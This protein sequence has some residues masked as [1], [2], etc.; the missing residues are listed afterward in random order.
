M[1]AAIPQDPS[2]FLAVIRDQVGAPKQ[3]QKHLELVRGVCDWKAFFEPL[4]LSVHGHART[5]AM[6]EKGVD[7]V[8]CF[9]FQRSDDCGRPG[10]WVWPQVDCLGGPRDVVLTA[11]MHMSSVEVCEHMVF[12]HDE[13]FQR[14][15]PT[16][17]APVPLRHADAQQ[18]KEYEKTAVAVHRA[19]WHMARAAQYLRSLVAEPPP[20]EPPSAGWF[21]E[22]ATPGPQWPN[23]L[24]LSDVR[25]LGEDKEPGALMVEDRVFKVRRTTDRP[26]PDVAAL[27]ASSSSAVPTAAKA[28]P[29]AAPAPP[30]APPAVPKAK[31]KAKGKAQA[32]PLCPG[33]GCGKCRWSPNGC[34]QCK[35]RKGW[36]EVDPGKWER[37]E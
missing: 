27:A 30:A 31:A 3:H 15:P 6:R 11:K 32:L 19:P 22:P 34:R 36:V 23:A 9:K 35:W 18:V 16:Q 21:W 7:A 37:F 10:G 2:D 29:A 8:H 5:H 25:G 20:P 4:G 13:A 26:P 33:L 1:S 17:P 28:P 12:C 14:L 24:A